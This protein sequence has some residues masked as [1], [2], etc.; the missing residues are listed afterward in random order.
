MSAIESAPATIP[1]TSAGTFTA[2]FTPPGGLERELGGDQVT[3]PGRLRESERRGQP[4]HRHEVRVIEARRQRRRSVR[5]SHPAD[6]LLWAR[7]GPRQTASFLFRGAFVRY[8]P[9]SPAIP[10]V[11]R[12]SALVNW[13]R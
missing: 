4:S 10:T 3:E 1:A 8:D 13:S 9:P 7:R 6:A 11:D 5:K 12:G 2:A